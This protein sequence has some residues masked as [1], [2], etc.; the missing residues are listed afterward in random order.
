[1]RI[2]GSA[3]TAN[4]A[5]ECL[6]DALEPDHRDAARRLLLVVLETGIDRGVRVVQTASLALRLRWR[7]ARLELL[8][9]ERDG[10]YGVRGKVVMAGRG[11]R[12]AARGRHDGERVAS[13]CDRDG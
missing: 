7:R 8:A 10:R 13:A 9:A 11:G 5:E 1:M 4:E 3:A 12:R 2:T 6:A